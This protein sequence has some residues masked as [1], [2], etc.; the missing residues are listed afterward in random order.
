MADDQE[1]PS[2]SPMEQF[3]SLNWGDDAKP[4]ASE[5]ATR[6]NDYEQKTALAE[7]NTRAGQAF[8]SNMAGFSQGLLDKVSQDPQFVHTALDIIPPTI[9]S[10]IDSNPSHPDERRQSDNDAIVNDLSQSVSRHAVQTAAERS[11]ESARSLLGNERISSFLSD[12]DK[13]GLDAYISMQSMARGADSA[14]AQKQ[15]AQQ[16]Q[17]RSATAAVMH[18]STLYD[19]ETNGIK[20]PSQWASSMM[21]NKDIAPQ[22]K[23]A[24]MHLYGRLQTNGDAE[25]SDPSMITSVLKAALS[26]TASHTDILNEAGNSL[27][28][29]DAFALA[30]GA[31]PMDATTRSTLGQ[32][33]DTMQRAR[34]ALMGADG[35][36][37][38]AGYAAF[39]RFANAAMTAI[40]QGSADFG[41]RHPLNWLP[42]FMPTGDDIVPS[43]PSASRRSLTQ[44][45]G[46]RG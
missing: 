4:W 33:S 20:F 28:S 3:A 14:A 45:F 17:D 44:I 37:G 38:A 2:G 18:A 26:G 35:E 8:V 27:R 16:A 6:V 29:V 19:D 39:G 9:F 36:N 5:V 25:Q 21:A 40:R 12:E 24:L 11:E 1:L 43:V 46:V 15:A 13:S 32:L 23:A 42:H 30:R 31:L 41:E 34:A 10:V 7:D 22:D